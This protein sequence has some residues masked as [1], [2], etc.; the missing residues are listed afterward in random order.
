MVK[1]DGCRFWVH[2]G[3]HQSEPQCKYG[4]CHRLPPKDGPKNYPYTDEDDWCG[5]G[6]APMGEDS[7][8]AEKRRGRPK[9]EQE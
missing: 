9:K 1:C 8:K 7:A 2:I 4:E 5:E 3:R 6:L